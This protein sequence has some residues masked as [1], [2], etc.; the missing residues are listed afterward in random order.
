LPERDTLSDHELLLLIK[1]EDQRAFDS[2]YQKYWQ[3]LYNTAYKRSRDK[4]QCRDIVQNVFIDLWAR[5]S[6]LVIENLPAFLHTAVRFQVFKEITRKP[7]AAMF[8]DDLDLIISS[9]IHT[10][11]PLLEKEIIDLLGYWIAALPAKRRLIFLLH[12]KEELSTRDISARIGVSRKTVQNQLT[13]A[14]QSL[15]IRLTHFISLTPIIIFLG[16]L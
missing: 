10:D 7:A 2:I 14:S 13:T 8:L 3:D 9:P 15:R 1:Q 16:I 6:E 4:E 12:Y 11:D 5:R